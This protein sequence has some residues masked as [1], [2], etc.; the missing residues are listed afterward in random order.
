MDPRALLLAA[1]LGCVAA[2]TRSDASSGAA[3]PPMELRRIDS[4]GIERHYRVHAPAGWDGASALPVVLAFHGGGG[5]AE[6]FAAHTELWR[7]ADRSG[8]LLVFP[9]GT[10]PAGVRRFRLQTWNAGDCCGAAARRGVDDVLFARDLVADLAGAYPLEHGRVFATGHSNGGMMAYRLAIEAPDLVRAIA[11]NAAALTVDGAPAAPVAVFALHGALDENVPAGGGVGSGL[12]GT[13]HRSQRES[14]A[15]FLRANGC[16]EPQIVET[17]GAAV[18]REA[19]SAAGAPVR[20]AWM[21]D[22]GHAWPGHGS[23][24]P[25]GEPCSYD[26][27]A[28]AEIWAFFA[29]F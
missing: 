20:H 18:I 13:D 9:E 11:P 28:N 21:T 23:G 10:P 2:A 17:R 3:P 27:D 12:S 22:H 25:N 14:L 29:R 16:G 1:A 26:L 7:E 19:D 6:Q 8:F 4:G 5:N 15:P 24:L